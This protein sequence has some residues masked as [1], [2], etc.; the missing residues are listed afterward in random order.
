MSWPGR[1]CS[2][3]NDF[4]EPPVTYIDFVFHTALACENGISTS[5]PSRRRDDSASS[6]GQTICSRFAYS[7]FPTR[8]KVRSRSCTTVAST[9]LRGK[10]ALFQVFVHPPANFRQS[11]AENDHAVVFVFIAR[12]PPPLV[13]AILF[14]P[15]RIAARGLDVAIGRRANPD[16]RVGGRNRRA[17]GCEASAFRRGSVC[18]RVSKYS[19][20]SP[21]ACACSRVDRR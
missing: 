3:P 16:I 8:I 10:A 4:R 18:R 11:F 15:A 7:S 19:K 5:R 13:V 12:L 20:S 6:S 1:S 21:L 2:L 14:P 17:G 9:L